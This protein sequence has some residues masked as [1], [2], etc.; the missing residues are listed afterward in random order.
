MLIK[1][2]KKD[3]IHWKYIRLFSLRLQIMVFYLPANVFLRISWFRVVYEI[4]QT[5]IMKLK[6]NSNC[7]WTR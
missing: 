6:L 5:N 1:R 7:N 2:S 4:T 3:K